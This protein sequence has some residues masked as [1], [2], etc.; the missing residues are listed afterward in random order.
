MEILVPVA[1]LAGMYFLNK[2]ASTPGVESF[3]TN[4]NIPDANYPA[5]L[6]DMGNTEI[7]DPEQTTSALSTGN[8]FVG[9][10]A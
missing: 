1:A 2:S 6:T 5:A 9:N 4:A 10:G 7:S 8:R 3:E